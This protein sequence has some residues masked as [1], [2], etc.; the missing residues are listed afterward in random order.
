MF[1]PKIKQNL[2][3]SRQFSSSLLGDSMKSKGKIEQ[4]VYLKKET[5]RGRAFRVN[6]NTPNAIIY[7]AREDQCSLPS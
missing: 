7:A 1:S 6:I 2:L 3:L 4:R 5:K